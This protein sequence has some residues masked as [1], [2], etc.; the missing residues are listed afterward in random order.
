MVIT[1]TTYLLSTAAPQVKA[2]S[3]AKNSRQISPPSL[4]LLEKSSLRDSQQVLITWICNFN[5]ECKDVSRVLDTLILE[6]SPGPGSDLR[7]TISKKLL[8]KLLHSLTL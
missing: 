8:R 3:K 4:F 5:L 6:F 7:E 2:A 1:S